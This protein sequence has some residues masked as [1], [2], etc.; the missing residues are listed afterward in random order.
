MIQDDLV[1][2]VALILIMIH[3]SLL[4]YLCRILHW[5]VLVVKIQVYLVF[6]AVLS[7]L[8]QVILV[9]VLSWSS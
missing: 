3:V 4:S 5:V 8:I 2:S 1:L 6:K 7:V 9:S